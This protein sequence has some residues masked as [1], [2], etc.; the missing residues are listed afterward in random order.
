MALAV[1]TKLCKSVSR[2]NCNDG[3][4]HA[5]HIYSTGTSPSDAFECHILDTPSL[6]CLRL[7]KDAGNIF[8]ALL[9][10]WSFCGLVI[11]LINPIWDIT[12]DMN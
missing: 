1:T 8:Q 12:V 4:L 11:H 6:S 10:E 3:V 2:S 5:P 7:R 9:T